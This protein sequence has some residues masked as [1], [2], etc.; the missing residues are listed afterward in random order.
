MSENQN[1]DEASKNKIGA[2]TSK[3]KGSKDKD[4]H[5]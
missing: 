2:K 3:S 4:G 5:S 1:N